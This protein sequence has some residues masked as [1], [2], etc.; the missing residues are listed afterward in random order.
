MLRSF[1]LLFSS[2]LF[3]S[4]ANPPLPAPSR[5]HFEVLSWNI[6]MLP[7][8][9]R[10]TGKRQRAEAIGALLSGGP[11][12]MLVFQEAF[13]G[14]A[15]RILRR[16]LGQLYPYECGPANRSGGIRANS[17]IWIL[18]QTPLQC[19]EE[20]D[21]RECEG[22]DDC[23]AHKGALLVETKWQGKPVQVLGTHLQAGGPHAIRHSQYAE[24]RELLDRHAREG[25]PQVVCGDMNTRRSDSLNYQTMLQTLDA[26][27]GALTGI[28]QY[29][30]DGAANDLCGGG[31][32]NRKVIDYIF[33]REMGIRWRKV[34]RFIPLL[35]KRWSR[36]HQDLSDHNP[37]AIRLA[38]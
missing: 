27:D 23:M 10:L 6:F 32:A 33:L 24:M 4:S 14:D 28:R 13:L 38:W 26:R 31:S 1:L 12:D 29:T 16:H 8:M 18:S 3:I 36:R 19:L 2:L 34:H 35:R 11:Y 17:G 21:Y 30:A 9:A 37:V 15:R 22:F 7:K 5:D 25:V 20:I